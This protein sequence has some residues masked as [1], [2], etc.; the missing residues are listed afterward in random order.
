MSNDRQ[1]IDYLSPAELIALM[2]ATGVIGVTETGLSDGRPVIHAAVKVVNAET[3]EEL[4]GGL[5]FSVVMFKGPNEPG[6][7]N[8]AIGTI[9]PAAELNV[10]LPRDY[11]NFC[12]QRFR[13]SR[14][15]PVDQSSFVIQMD[16]VLRN[17]TRE[18]IKFSFGLWGALFSN[19][20]F[21]LVGRERESLIAVAEA[22]AQVHTD[23]ASQTASTPDAVEVPP[24][25]ADVTEPAPESVMALE[26]EA[27]V[28]GVVAE[29][30]PTEVAVEGV[31]TEAEAEA[32]PEAEAV[33]SVVD[34]GPLP[35]DEVK[36]EEAVAATELVE[37]PNVAEP[38][39]EPEN[40]VVTA[41]A[42]EEPELSIAA[43][44]AAVEDVATEE[45]VTELAE[46]V[47]AV[48]AAETDQSKEPVA[49]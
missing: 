10:A 6:Y 47:E 5:P 46:H 19:V 22:Y 30:A 31:P 16:L 14:V 39:P 32:V 8:I 27:I 44:P 43:G 49:A 2:N 41:D 17:A 7:S 9:V 34:V 3:G 23:F 29:G 13:F 18:Y 25:P 45:L 33:A 37:E 24:L 42:V 28:S 26:A 4:P 1:V 11:F 48:S 36:V 20:L 21:E 40:A 35:E 12:N 38:E 15:F